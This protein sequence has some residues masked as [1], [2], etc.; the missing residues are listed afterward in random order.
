MGLLRRDTLHILHMVTLHMDIQW[1][2]LDTDIPTA[3]MVAPTDAT[4]DTAGGKSLNGKG[5]VEI[6]SQPLR[7]GDE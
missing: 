6:S 5:A 1:W 2:E 3:T 4:M 7:F